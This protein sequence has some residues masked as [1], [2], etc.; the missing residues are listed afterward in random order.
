MYETGCKS[1]SKLKPKRLKYIYLCLW[2]KSIKCDSE[3]NCKIYLTL[4]CFFAFC[5]TATPGLAPLPLRICD[6]LSMYW[7]N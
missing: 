5:H 7:V 1:F 6:S 2:S 3:I 4:L